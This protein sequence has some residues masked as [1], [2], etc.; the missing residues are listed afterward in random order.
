MH[1]TRR[2]LIV[3][4]DEQ[5]RAMLRQMLERAGY[6]VDEAVDGIQAA[7]AY[8]QHT[9]ALIITDLL[10]PEKDGLETIVE[11]RKSE[12]AIPIIAIS[13][14]GV[15]GR[16]DLLPAAKYLGAARTFR[17]PFERQELLDAVA[18]LIGPAS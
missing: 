15:T 17:K 13:G 11:L 12:P 8:A 4:D 9:P 14:G 10:M 18:G 16:L 1:D 2:I 6:A 7:D 5:L 3:D